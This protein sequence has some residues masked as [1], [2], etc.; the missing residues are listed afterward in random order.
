MGKK[1]AVG[2]DLGGT[3][4]ATGIVDQDGKL[5]DQLV[6]D[7]DA[8]EGSDAVLE[9]MAQSVKT[10]LERQNA[11]PEDVLGI[12]VCSPGPLERETGLVLFAPNLGWKNVYLGPILQEKTGI[13]TYVENDAN[14]AA[15]AEKWFGAGRGVENMVYITVS[16]GVGSGI[17]INDRLY[18]GTHGTAGEVGHIVIEGDGPLCGCGQRG[19]LESLASGTAI[20]RMAKEALQAGA[21]SVI[22]DLVEGDLDAISAKVV[23]EAAKQGDK[24]AQEVLDK[25]FYYLSLGVVNV[26]NLFDPEVVVI[27][28]GVSKLGDMLFTPVIEQVR[29][30]AVAGPREKTR[31]VP[32]ALGVDAGM[33]GACS[34]VLDVT[35]TQSF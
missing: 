24:V 2:V 13:T 21:E 33:L 9:R 20:A 7:T 4:I 10:L 27:G 17:I 34:L 11:K 23:G 22:R 29:K 19:C 35:K 6:C 26:L 3:K 32:A 14:A 15:L 30:K 31:I 25:A 12:G 18:A 5:L 8:K 28:G 1:Y 16:T